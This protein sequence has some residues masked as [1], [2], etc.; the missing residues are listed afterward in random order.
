MG[1]WMGETDCEGISRL[2]STGVSLAF[3]YIFSTTTPMSSYPRYRVSIPL[4][5]W[6]PVL[7]EVFDEMLA[8]LFGIYCLAAAAVVAGLHHVGY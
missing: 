5:R 2:T 8:D 7:N 4:K 1:V 3:T 6:T